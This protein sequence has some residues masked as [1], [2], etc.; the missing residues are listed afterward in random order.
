LTANPFVLEHPL[1]G[2]LGAKYKKTATQIVF[3]F[4]Q[5]LGIVP[6]TGTSSPSHMK[7]DLNAESFQLDESELEALETIAA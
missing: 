4:S 7:E 1:V 6:L 2:K 5:Q 3:R